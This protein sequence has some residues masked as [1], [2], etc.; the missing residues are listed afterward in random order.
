MIL[1]TRA[2]YTIYV[3]LVYIEIFASK[4]AESD[5]WTR[6]PF[7]W[8]FKS[9]QY[10]PENIYLRGC[11]LQKEL[12]VTHTH[13]TFN[14]SLI[15]LMAIIGIYICAITSYFIIS[16]IP[17]RIFGDYRIVLDRMA[18]DRNTVFILKR[19]IDDGS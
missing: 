19:F 17:Q 13:H 16:S 6:P 18:K 11:H 1:C 5:L 2:L 3:C 7:T 4:M 12:T 8:Y 10:K 14:T 9:R 15:A